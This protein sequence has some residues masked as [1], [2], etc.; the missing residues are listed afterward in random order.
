ML[1]NNAFLAI[2]LSRNHLV[3][4]YAETEEEKTLM[5]LQAIQSHLKQGGKALVQKEAQILFKKRNPL[6]AV[7]LCPETFTT[8]MSLYSFSPFFH[9]KQIIS[10]SWATTHLMGIYGGVSCFITFVVGMIIILCLKLDTRND[11][12]VRA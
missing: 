1:A 5:Q 7:L 9:G 12:R 10:A 11:Y 3:Q 8:I 6:G 2:H 4:Q